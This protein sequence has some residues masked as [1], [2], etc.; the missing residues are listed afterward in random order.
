MAV[1][2]SVKIKEYELP[3][4]IEQEDGGTF[5]AACP[6]WP[7]CYAQGDTVDEVVNEAVAVA[8]SLVELYEEEAIVIPLPVRRNI[9][10]LRKKEVIKFPLFVSV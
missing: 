3:L 5:V 10:S 9:V 7:D 2:K 8:A 4:V 1:K 6:E